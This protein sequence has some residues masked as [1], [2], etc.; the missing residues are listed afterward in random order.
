MNSEE[1]NEIQCSG[2]NILSN[3]D[4]SVGEIRD[5]I[6]GDKVFSLN[7][8]AH[9]ILPAILGA[10]C[11]VL[12]SIYGFGFESLRVKNTQNKQGFHFSLG[13]VS[14]LISTVIT[15]T[16]NGIPNNGD[17]RIKSWGLAFSFALLPGL[18][19]GKM[20]KDS[21]QISLL[22]QQNDQLSVSLQ[23]LVSNPENY[24]YPQA[25]I[26][27]ETTLNIL[28]NSNNDETIRDSLT[29]SIHLVNKNPDKLKYD[30][31]SSKYLEILS[32]DK[33]VKKQNPSLYIMEF[34]NLESELYENQYF[35]E[36]KKNHHN[37]LDK[38]F[39][40]SNVFRITD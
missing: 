32:F 15:A 6:A 35:L 21:G 2:I 38:S 17:K 14:A 27:A 36:Y 37:K 12:I 39:N 19:I 29:Q 33:K 11:V 18:A 3:I 30:S 1:T 16:V 13:F 9:V 34:K 23:K 8:L 26:V 40:Q 28:E 5:H 31:V 24:S 25:S 22:K 7:I 4:S 20:T 10:L